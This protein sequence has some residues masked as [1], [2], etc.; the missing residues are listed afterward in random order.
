MD[1]FSTFVSDGAAE[2]GTQGW[3]GSYLD[4]T[5]PATWTSSDPLDVPQVV[6]VD[7]LIQ[8]H[9]NLQ[10]AMEKASRA[11]DP[12]PTEPTANNRV[13]LNRYDGP[14]TSNSEKFTHG[15]YMAGILVAGNSASGL[16]GMAPGADFR[17]IDSNEIGTRPPCQHR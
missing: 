8:P 4:L 9:W 13:R 1:Q 10:R 7:S 5:E 2:V 15:T 11:F 16:L 6:L 3:I 12:A 17:W 14:A